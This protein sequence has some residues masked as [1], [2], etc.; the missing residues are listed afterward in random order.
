MLQI[1]FWLPDYQIYQAVSVRLSDHYMTTAF[2]QTSLDL[3]FK[4]ICEYIFKPF[5]LKDKK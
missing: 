1:K 5:Y 4:I 3:R 2:Q